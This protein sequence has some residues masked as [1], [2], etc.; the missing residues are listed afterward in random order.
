LTADGFNAEKNALGPCA[1]HNSAFDL[2]NGGMPI[3]GQ[4]PRPLVRILLEVRQ[5]DIYAVGLSSMPYNFQLPSGG[6]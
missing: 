6:A 1:W 2:K 4:A 5:G 3:V